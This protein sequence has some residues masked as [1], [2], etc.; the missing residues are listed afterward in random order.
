MEIR[1]ARAC[2]TVASFL[3]LLGGSGCG[4][5]NSS[6]P[7]PTELA[8]QYKFDPNDVSGWQLDP[9]DSMAFQILEEGTPADLFSFMD[10]GADLYTDSGCTVSLYESLV[11][12]NQELAVIWA[13]Y[14][15][16]DAK[17]T[18]MFNT[19]KSTAGVS[20]PIP[21]Y[22]ASDAIGKSALTVHTVYAHVGAMYYEM[23][24]SG[25]TDATSAF[26]AASQILD[27]FRSKTR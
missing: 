7:T 21:N 5:G 6:P 3:L 11:S 10:G 23:Q 25:F 22:N 17:T 16:T 8:A 19:R 9:N 4:S 15:G 1:V 18:A 12:S 13:M 24:M 2:F 14:F 26:Q 20:L 27:V